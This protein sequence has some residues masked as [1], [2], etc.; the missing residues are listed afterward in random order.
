MTVRYFPSSATALSK[1]RSLWLKVIP[2]LPLLAFGYRHVISQPIYAYHG[3][4]Y[5]IPPSENE[6]SKFLVDV[7]DKTNIP[8]FPLGGHNYYNDRDMEACLRHLGWLTS[9]F[10]S[11][12][13]W[14]E[15][16]LQ[17]KAKEGP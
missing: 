7:G 2:C 15:R 10:I 13:G 9:Q 3:S 14:E 17:K 11:E 5:H 4:L 8:R 12:V 6:Y 16:Y 1:E